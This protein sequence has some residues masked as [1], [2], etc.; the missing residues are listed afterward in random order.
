MDTFQYFSGLG[1]SSKKRYDALRDFYFNGGKAEEVAKKY[2]YT[3]SAFYSLAKEFREHL[4]SGEGDSFFFKE[5]A[6]GRK[7]MTKADGLNDLVISLRKQNNST[8]NIVAIAHSK[9]FSVSYGYVFQLLAKEGFMR[10]P[11]R[12]NEFK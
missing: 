3:L 4:K 8:E 9:D 5:T 12:S 6:P 2:G 10:L 11:R 1:T 7:P